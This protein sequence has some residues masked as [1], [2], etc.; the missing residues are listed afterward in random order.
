MVE[1]LELA[2]RNP[3]LHPRVTVFSVVGRVLGC[4]FAGFHGLLV[5]CDTPTATSTASTGGSHWS[6]KASAVVGNEHR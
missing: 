3:L 4:L 1:V 6:P 2:T 5:G